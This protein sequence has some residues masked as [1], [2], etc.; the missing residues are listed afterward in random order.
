MA[1]E[2]CE[3]CKEAIGVLEQAYICQ[4]HIVCQ[5]CNAK[6]NKSEEAPKT[7]KLENFTLIPCPYCKA[8]LKVQRTRKRASKFKCQFCAREIIFDPHQFVYASPYLTLDQDTY[9]TFLNQLDRWIFAYGSKKDYDAMKLMLGRKFKGEP[10]PPD[11]IWGLIN[12]SLLRCK[13]YER[14]DLE[15]LSKKFKQFEK[16]LKR[17]KKKEAAEARRKAKTKTQATVTVPRCRLCN[18]EM[19]Q[20]VVSSGNVAGIAV[21]LLVFAAG[22]ILTF[23][24]LFC[25]GW[26]IGIPLCILAL[27]MGGKRKRVF[28]CRS[29]GAIYDRS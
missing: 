25:G 9:I 14:K 20:S 10:R 22:L 23:G 18:S 11:I 24:G 2:I 4:G 13:D 17:K 26:L 12:Q 19:K 1:V 15:G 6:L 16:Q 7:K 3:N 21:A 5:R 8:E 29:C 27:F 28:K